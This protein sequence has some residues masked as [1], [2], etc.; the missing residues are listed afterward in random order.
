MKRKLRHFIKYV[1][2]FSAMLLLLLIFLPRSYPLPTATIR[3][4][5]QY[6]DL[7]TGSHI[8][9]TFISGKGIRKPEPVIFINGGPGGYISD[10]AISL[11]AKLSDDGF[12]LY[13]YD[14]IGSGQSARLT[15]INEYT[16]TRHKADLNEI[17][18]KT[19]A[20]KVILIGQS[21]G[22]ILAA[23]YAADHPEKISK[24]IFT[25]PG[26]LYPINRE[27]AFIKSPDS[28]HL[29]PPV[30][31]NAQAN[32]KANNIRTK[33]M[34]FFAK[35]FGVKLATDKEA[36][37][38][39]TML[40]F[41]LNKSTVKDTAKIA[42]PAA[43]GGFYASVMTVNS[44]AT[45]KDIRPILAKST[46]PVLIMKAQYDNQPWGF[47]YEYCTLFKT[48]QLVIIPDAGHSIASEQPQAY[49]KTI[50]DFIN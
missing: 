38:F 49:L 42:A 26:P 35:R 28:L 18:K 50:L 21:W 1:L 20:K 14:Q 34:A 19:G 10:N 43:G 8:G 48:H 33:T 40:D 2:V 12:D 22:A 5:V 6:W 9:Y 23:F 31:S 32:K 4:N 41:E 11:R 30:F 36:D 24:I 17:I 13:F 29:Y 47:T 46:I 25:C 39:E 16:V 37:E 3:T 45:C 27:Q 44:L 7:S 15:N